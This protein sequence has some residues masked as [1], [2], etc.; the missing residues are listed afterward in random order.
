MSQPAWSPAPDRVAGANIT[1][2]IRLVRAELDPL[3]VDYASLY[4]FSIRSPESFWRAVW[5]FG[6]VVGEPGT[7]VLLDGDQMPGARWFPDARLNFAENLL[8][9]RDDREALVFESE[10]GASRSLSYAELY[11][12]VAAAA[13]ALQAAG[14][15]R[16]DRVAGFMPNLPETVVAMLAATSIGA[17]WS[18]VSPDF[19]THGVVDRLSQ[20][21]PRVLFTAGAYR[22][23]GKVFDCLERVREVIDRIPSIELVVVVPYL[24]PD[25]QTGG[26]G[27]A[28]TF[29]DFIDV[30]AAAPEFEKFPFDQPVYILYSSGTTGAP[31]CITHGAGAPC[32]S[33]SANWCCTAT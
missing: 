19:G 16:G 12:Q 14:T 4:D 10:T 24:E 31:K 30:G 15:G 17:T 26:I 11:R 9:F 20:I 2:F 8:R 3:V 28:R 21:E 29:A 22:Y 5:E 25:A 23:N 7:R 33:T 18:S 27:I 1:R 6:E 13:A 32:S